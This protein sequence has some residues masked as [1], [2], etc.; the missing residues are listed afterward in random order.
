[1]K[2][3]E[4]GVFTGQ[5]PFLLSGVV[6]NGGFSVLWS[7]HHSLEPSQTMPLLLLLLYGGMS[8]AFY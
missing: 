6:E 1:L 8:L 3:L 5:M 7:L 4:A 2:C